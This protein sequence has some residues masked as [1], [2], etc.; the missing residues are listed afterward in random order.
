VE[1]IHIA[2]GNGGTG[3]AAVNVPIAATDID[4]L[5]EYAQ[6]QRFDLTVIGP[7][8]PL[9]LGLS[10]ALRD[11]GLKVFGPSAKAARIESSK[12]FGKDF[13]RENRIPTADYGVFR[14]HKAALG[15]LAGHP[16]PIVVKASGL[17]AGK[18]SI[19]CHTD[20][21]ARE[22]LSRIMR[23]RVFGEAGD[24]VVIEEF[25]SGQETSVL[26]F[27]DGNTVVPMVL[28]QDHKAAYDGDLGPNTGGMGCYAPARFIDSA[29]Q[30]R[31]VNEV[32]QPT[33]DGMR[34]AGTPYVG[35]LYAGMM[36]S[37]D[38]FSALEFNCRFGD[39]ETQVTVPLLET[40]LVTVMLACI[41]G[42]LDS[43]DLRWSDKACVCVAMASGGYP[44]QYKRGY[45]IHG[46]EQAGQLPNTVIFHAG[47]KREG[48]RVVTAG[49]RVL[50]VTAWDDDLKGAI[51][52]AYSAV[53][54]IHWPEVMFRRD[55][56]AKGLKAQ[57]GTP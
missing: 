48:D 6:A 3:E 44:G 32:L 15:Y 41:D 26:A 27:T 20:Q 35:V 53:D 21:E 34:R 51:E 25:L 46:L 42:K 5:V 14:D 30:E 47:T 54:L 36:I 45:E 22:A 4:A 28:S 9:A 16:A 37:D 56:G 19:V 57:G 33:V 11:A 50:G 10:D 49:G 13:M 12:A 29:L 52:H 18:G 40:D 7:E 17:A 23:D 38:D 43:V 1:E 55:I 8:L 24:L 2:P 39:P 31:M